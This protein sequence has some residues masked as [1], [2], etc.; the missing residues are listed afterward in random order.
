MR[1]FQG[2]FFIVTLILLSAGCKYQKLLKDGTPDERLTAAKKYYNKGDYTRALPLFDALI[3][4]FGRKPQAEDIYYYYAYTHYGMGDFLQASY[5]FNNFTQKYP[6]S[7]YTEECAF[8]VAKCAYHQSPAHYLD[9]TNTRNAIES[10]QLFINK[11]PGSKYVNDGNDLIDEL[12]SKLHKKAYTNAMLYYQM[13][14]YKS[15]LVAFKNAIADYPDLPQIEE[16]E[17]LVVKSAYLY[18]QQSFASVQG[19]RLE[20]AIEEGKL[21]LE[22]EIE[23]N[24]YTSEVEKIISDSKKQIKK[25]EETQANQ[26]TVE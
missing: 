26:T 12:R 6:R 14:S 2:T 11:Y 20:V 1:V 13:G 15:S 17:Y 23:N 10:I 16:L 5:N 4:S 21:F 25:L 7:K 9:P 22:S 8:M 24:T 3:G 19:E 18:A